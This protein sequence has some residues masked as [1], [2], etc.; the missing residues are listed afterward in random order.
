[1]KTMM[2]YVLETP[3]AI[4]KMISDTSNISEVLEYLINRKI[5]HIY[6]AGSG[7]SYS[8][9]LSCIDPLETMLHIP[10]YAYCAMEFVDNVKVIEE[11]SLVIG[12]SQA[13]QSNST[14]QALDKARNHGCLTIVVT[15]EN[16]SPIVKHA[17][18]C[19]KMDIEEAIGP[20]TKGYYCSTVEVILLFAQLL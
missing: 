8:A 11:N 17:D 10:V 2:N 16:P 12:F 15:A 9:A 13:G 18:A 3:Q 4:R 20:K 14:I 6:V 5:D 1:M 7:T 19:L